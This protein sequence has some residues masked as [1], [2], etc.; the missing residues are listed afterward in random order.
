MKEGRHAG[1][2]SEVDAVDDATAVVGATVSGR[3]SMGVDRAE[4][5]GTESRPA[6][7]SPLLAPRSSLPPRLRIA[8]AQIQHETNTFSVT[9]TDLAAFER[10]GLRY[11]AAVEPVERGTNTAFGG[12]FEAA[13][14]LDIDLVP[15]MSV[16]ATPSGMVTADAL[17]ALLERLT[18][19]L[20]LHEP[21]G[22]V[23]ALHG[24]M[25]SERYR[26]ADG[27]ILAQVRE[28]IGLDTPLVVSLDL[29]ANISPA[30][31][32]EADVLFGYD[33]YPHVD[34]AARA[35]E[36]LGICRR[37]IVERLRPAAALAKPPMLPTSQRMTT[38]RSPMRSLIHRAHEMERD[39]RVLAVTI[40]GGFPPADV[41]EA[42]LSVVVSTIDDPQLA[43][44]LA[45]QL[46]SLA[47]DLRDGFLGGVST[48]EEAAALVARRPSLPAPRSPLP[49]LLV[50]IGDNP[51]TGGPGDS[52]ELVR[53]LL[54]HRVEGAAVAIVVD[55]ET[56]RQATESGPGA[57]IR[58]ALGGRTD[59][60]HGPPL[61]AEAAILRLTDGRY[62]NRGPMM[63]G[64]QV[65]LGPTA[66]L[67][68]GDPP[69]EVVVTSHAETPIDPEVFR[70]A[71]IEPENRRVLAIK[72]KGHFRAAFT[73]IVSDILLVEGP[74]ITGADL[75][76]LPFKH[77]RRPIWPLDS[78]ATY[79]RAAPFVDAST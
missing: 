68:F 25:V 1:A 27:H 52:V 13:D 66:V 51:W 64:V 6:S 20:L 78:E 44:E 46:A 26:D 71:G 58:V 57:T 36:A 39:P 61:E 24:A 42:S 9:P 15:I 74:G 32:A 8:A 35:E 67:S 70:M 37:L 62:V 53:F 60:L 31:L 10:S 48:W 54:A 5:S 11:G 47:W 55:P 65:D 40:A 17:D 21:D 30:M 12:F 28:A 4:P 34:M 56:V 33:T 45:E 23:L 2:G 29:H 41:E 76:R 59:R 79:P 63:T 38:D 75:S 43:A 72:G 73:P 50:D 19:S 69:V 7:P 22:V 18:A 3:P 16:W 14:A 49:L 77:I